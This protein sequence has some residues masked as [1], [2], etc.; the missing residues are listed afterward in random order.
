MRDYAGKKNLSE[1]ILCMQKITNNNGDFLLFSFLIGTRKLD[2]SISPAFR[3]V[4]IL[5]ATGHLL[6]NNVERC[7]VSYIE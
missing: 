5:A 7:Y 6:F 2:L 3:R 1:Y 4:V